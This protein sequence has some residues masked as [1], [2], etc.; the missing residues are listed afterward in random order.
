MVS[1]TAAIALVAVTAVAMAAIGLRYTHGGDSVEEFITARGS[2]GTPM[3]VATLLA[4]NMGAWI[5]FSPAEAGAAFGGIAAVAGYA[6]GS[7]VASLAYVLVGPRIYRLIPRGHT[8]TE[9]AYVRYGPVMYAYVL[10]ISVTFM[11]I[12]LAANMT[13][14]VGVLSLVAGVPAW[15]T[16]AVIGG[17]VLL[18]TAYG[19][20]RASI[21]TDAV[22][23]LLVLPL[24]GLVFALTLVTLGGPAT[25][26]RT[27]SAT[28]P[29]LLDPGFVPG[30]L[31]GVYVVVAIAG[32]ELL[33]QSWWQ[34]VYAAEDGETVRRS[35]GISALAI[36]PVVL[37]AGLFGV[38]AAGYGLVEGP[39]DASVALFLVVLATLPEWVGLVVVLAAVL[40]VMSTADTLFNA[41]ASVVTGDLPLLLDSPSERTLTLAARI[42]TAAV[43]L[44]ATVIGAQ[45]YSVLEL[46]LTAD[47]FAVATA[48]PLLYGLYSTRASEYGMLAASVAGLLV[49][50]AY[51]PTV[52]GPLSALPLLGEL[53]P[54]P[55]FLR[56]FLG[57]AAVSSG[58][59]VISVRLTDAGFDL[60]RLSREIGLIGSER[61]D[62][63]PAESE[64]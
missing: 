28:D 56:A 34:R 30:L 39:G 15:Q 17:F 18:Y 22:Q 54:D 46:F 58:L 14:I 24:L 57:A 10:A 8:L 49:G 60:G 53:L 31:F 9:Y 52:H 11:F 20:L 21:L 48:V 59:A 44:G 12:A 25:I 19:G 6:L 42:A 23:L 35:F 45:A 64:D 41:I 62:V 26:G 29:T 32:A 40:L 16:A 3:L 27:V 37:F 47:M 13:G 5:L 43:A 4:S 63:A 33:N 51:L 2:V 1:S 55:S 50:L 38:I 7:A 36:V 61:V